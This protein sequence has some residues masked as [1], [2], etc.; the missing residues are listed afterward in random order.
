LKVDDNAKKLLSKLSSDTDAYMI[1]KGILKTCKKDTAPEDLSLR[2]K[3]IS[4][5]IKCG[6]DGLI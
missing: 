6:P 4:N 2:F 5:Y 1:V 3:E